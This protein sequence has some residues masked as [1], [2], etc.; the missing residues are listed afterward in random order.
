VLLLF[1]SLDA[2][3]GGVPAN[4]S[5]PLETEIEGIR[6]DIDNITQYCQVG[7]A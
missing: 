5:T 6:K 3:F 1:L 4:A 7:A 2:S